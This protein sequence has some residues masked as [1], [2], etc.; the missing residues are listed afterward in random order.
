[1]LGGDA[2]VP[3]APHPCRVVQQSVHSRSH[4]P[5]NG[6]ARCLHRDNFIPLVH[7]VSAPLT[8]EI[9]T[10]KDAVAVAVAA[11]PAS[12]VSAWA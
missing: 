2:K 10:T 8:T 4:V 1:M 6:I 5:S 3:A 11:A 12:L 7:F 9:A